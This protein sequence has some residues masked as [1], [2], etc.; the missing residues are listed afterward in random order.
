MG[1]RR[2]AALRGLRGEHVTVRRAEVRLQLGVVEQVELIACDEKRRECRR[3]RMQIHA[4]RDT[5]MCRVCAQV[6][7][8]SVSLAKAQNRRATAAAPTP[9]T[10]AF[11]WFLFRW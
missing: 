6:D 4:R 9:M 1:H 2:I 7:G 3:P 10:A 5:C 8:A 11:H